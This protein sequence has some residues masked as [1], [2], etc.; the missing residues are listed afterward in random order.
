MASAWVQNCQ[1][2]HRS[3]VFPDPHYG[4]NLAGDGTGGCTNSV[5]RWYSEW[6][7]YKGVFAIVSAHP[8]FFVVSLF[9]ISTIYTST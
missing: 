6:P 9:A 8:F 1:F 3:N 7:N 5:R 4:E 2:K